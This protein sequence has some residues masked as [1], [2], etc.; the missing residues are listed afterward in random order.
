MTVFVSVNMVLLRVLCVFVNTSEVKHLMTGP[1]GNSEF[2]S[3]LFLEVKPRGTLRVE[4]KQNVKCFVIQC[5]SQL[6]NRKKCEK[7]FVLR[8][9]V[10]KFA[11]IFR[12]TT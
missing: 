2:C 11:A 7:V 10:H 4:E 12:C 1:K 3:S 8:W 5:T 6:K 9:L